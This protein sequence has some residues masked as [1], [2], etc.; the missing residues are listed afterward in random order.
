[1]E[2]ELLDN[3]VI[4][5]GNEGLNLYDESGYGKPFEDRLELSLVEAAYLL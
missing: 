5:W 4:V 1:M 2:G 3:R